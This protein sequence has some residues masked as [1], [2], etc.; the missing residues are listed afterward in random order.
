[1]GGSSGTPTA[2]ATT[3]DPWSLERTQLQVLNALQTIAANTASART[4]ASL[5]RSRSPASRRRNL[6]IAGSRMMMSAFN[7][8]TNAIMSL[9]GAADSSA[10]STFTGSLKILSGT[11]GEMFTPY[12][13]EAS[14][15]M[16]TWADYM[17]TQVSPA[18]KKMISTITIGSVAVLGIGAVVA[19]V[20]PLFASFGTVAAGVGRVLTFGLVSNPIIAG[21]VG[22]G[23]AIA[24]V[25]YAW[26][27][28][29]STASKA[30]GD[31]KVEG[32]NV[33]GAGGQIRPKGIQ[34]EELKKLFPADV[35]EK[36]KGAKLTPEDQADL[37]K[38]VQQDLQKKMEEVQNEQ[39]QNIKLEENIVGKRKE[40]VQNARAAL[41]A[42]LDK[43]NQR[44]REIL[45]RMPSDTGA[46]IEERAKMISGFNK[47]ADETAKR[48]RESL[49]VDA[50][51][52][53]APIPDEMMRRTTWT[54]GP[55]GKVPLADYTNEFKPNKEVNA[56]LQIFVDEMK[57]KLEK[58]SKV[59]E[60]A[61]LGKF[62]GKDRIEDIKL[63]VK[64]RY[65]D[66]MSFRESVQTQAL[67]IPET[68]TVA[69]LKELERVIT[70]LGEK[71]LSKTT[72]SS[73]SLA[74]A[75]RSLIPMQE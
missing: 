67:N 72:D 8:A 73:R 29:G 75:L 22:V 21:L 40:L 13:M 61:G 57:A 35:L 37:I 66:A 60:D 23:A 27:N 26:R 59:A 2:T 51:K 39:F 47:E 7:Q 15:W 19:R 52:A 62:M 36:L 54:E 70:R 43:I 20:I 69:A 24:G 25:T 48:I 49:R 50:L 34:D 30:I 65:T 58:I 9:V 38:G 56:P 10:M 17:D 42:E 71:M 63:P 64:S 5:N 12:V 55:R 11:I 1:M 18:T 3:A 4:T 44:E 74:D 46:Q 68:E 6:G 53:G 28:L 32:I 45:S 41:K 33:P 31:M 14:G 16:Q